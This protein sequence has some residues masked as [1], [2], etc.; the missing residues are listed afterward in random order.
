[1]QTNILELHEQF[2]ITFGVCVCVCVWAHHWFVDSSL[3]L[4][5]ASMYLAANKMQS[6]FSPNKYW[7]CVFLFK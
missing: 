4:W 1:M 7:I 5:H 2:K 6:C 3:F